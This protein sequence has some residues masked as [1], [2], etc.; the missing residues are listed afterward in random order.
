MVGF[1]QIVFQVLGEDEGLRVLTRA[2]M[3]LGNRV[4]STFPI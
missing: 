1:P 4:R 3:I 2:G